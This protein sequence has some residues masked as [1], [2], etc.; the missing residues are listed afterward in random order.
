MTDRELVAA[1]RARAD[2]A[3]ARL[4][5]AYGRDVHAECLRLLG[6]AEAAQAALRDTLVVAA[7]HADRLADPDLLREWLLAIAR[8]ECRRVPT[9]HGPAP[10]D[11]PAS[12][13]KALSGRNEN[14]G[15]PGRPGR[16]VHSGSAPTRT[17]P[18]PPVPP[19]SLRVRVLSAVTG[20]G[21]D[22]YRRHV[23]A[24]AADLDRHGF[25]R[26]H[27]CSGP[28]GALRQLAPALAVTLA[29]L[30]LIGLVHLTGADLSRRGTD[31]PPAQPLVY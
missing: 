21:T 4:F 3:C 19:A 14:L 9:A 6:D 12:G 5:D 20:P 31:Q 15:H 27:A 30:L 8:A 7:A 29:V 11:A 17:A 25:P 28:R 24:R 23:A 22:G 26:R 10:A 18:V 13:G 2:G 1:L 16:P